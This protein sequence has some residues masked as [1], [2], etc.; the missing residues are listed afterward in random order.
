MGVEI[1][2]I[3]TPKPKDNTPSPIY[4]IRMSANLEVIRQAYKWDTDIETITQ[5]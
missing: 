2:F 1:Y 5:P 4:L 3:D